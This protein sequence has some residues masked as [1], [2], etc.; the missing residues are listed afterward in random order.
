MVGQS[1][2]RGRYFYYRCN[3][4]YL[5]D[6]E[7]RCS[8]RQVRKDALESA[9]LGVIEDLLADPELAIGMAERLRSGTDHAA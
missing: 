5:S 1:V 7:K 6:E 3:R 8:S 4:L 9:V 2:Q